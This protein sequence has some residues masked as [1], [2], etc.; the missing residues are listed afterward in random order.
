M[1]LTMADVT[2]I[3][4][5]KTGDEV[6]LLGDG[7]TAQDHANIAETIPYEILCGVHVPSRRLLPTG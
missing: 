1:N 4:E 2:E 6:V 5:A 3:S 7:I